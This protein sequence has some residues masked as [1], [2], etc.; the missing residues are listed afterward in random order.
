[1]CGRRRDLGARVSC[2]AYSPPQVFDAAGAAAT[3]AF[4]T[5]AVLWK[6]MVP[7]RGGVAGRRRGE[8]TEGKDL[9]GPAIR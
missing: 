7:R 8:G 9:A 4:V 3:E 6:D 5:S 1:M 2:L